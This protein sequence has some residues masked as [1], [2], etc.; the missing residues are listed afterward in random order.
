M[1]SSSPSSQPG[2]SPLVEQITSDVV[3]IQIRPA[4]GNRLHLA[5]VTNTSMP[6]TIPGAVSAVTVYGD[7]RIEYQ[8]APAMNEP[9]GGAR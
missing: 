3:E 2:S 9:E 5:L 6:E 8:A 7:G 1:P 4:F